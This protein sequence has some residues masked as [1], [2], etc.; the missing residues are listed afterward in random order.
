MSAGT[1]LT[2]SEYNASD[3]ETANT[4]Q[5]WVLP[6]KRDV[7]PRY[8]QASF[9]AARRHNRW[10]LLVSP[11]GT[12]SSLWVHQQTW[13]SRARL[14][15]GQSLQYSLH[16]DNNSG[17]YLFVIDGEVSIADEILLARDGIG[18]RDTRQ[19]SVQATQDSE[20]LVMEVPAS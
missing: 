5:I 2:H 13:F 17:A 6:N 4:L 7:A 3:T 18:L 1:G 12:D 10:Q 11:D 19:F 9:D 20:V 15:A 16:G 14:D 8:D